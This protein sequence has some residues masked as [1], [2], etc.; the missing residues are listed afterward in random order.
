MDLVEIEKSHSGDQYLGLGPKTPGGTFPARML[1]VA[2]D[3]LRS[4]NICTLFYEQSSS[5]DKDKSLKTSNCTH[6]ALEF[7][8]ENAKVDFEMKLFNVMTQRLAQLADAGD[9]RGI[10]EREA[11]APTVVQSPTSPGFQRRGSSMSS[12][13]A[14]ASRVSFALKLPP[15]TKM[16]P[17]TIE[18]DSVLSPR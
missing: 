1:T 18:K 12:S 17:I 3:D 6:L 7:P 14:N 5:K 4:W 16:S 2:K 9:A 11:R 15:L 8:N 10:A 13:T